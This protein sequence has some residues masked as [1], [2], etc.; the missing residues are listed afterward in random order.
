MDSVARSKVGRIR[1]PV[2][3]DTTL[4]RGSHLQR[5]SAEIFTSCSL[6]PVPGLYTFPKPMR[7]R[8]LLA[9]LLVAVSASLYSQSPAGHPLKMT[10]KLSPEQV[11]R[12]AIVI[13]T[14]ADTPQ[15]ISDE[16]YDLG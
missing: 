9:S 11:H 7:T 8:E 16:N 2:S 5:Y 15:R 14:H 12:S 10:T 4:D 3:A 13:D 6:I 1:R